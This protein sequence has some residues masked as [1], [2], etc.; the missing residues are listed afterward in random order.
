MTTAR[1]YYQNDHYRGF[2]VDGHADYDAD[3]DIV[4]AAVSIST[5]SAVN[6]LE[7]LLGIV[8]DC[9]EDEARGYLKCQLPDGLTADLL[10]QSDLIIGH[11]AIAL[12]SLAQ[13][14]PKHV[15]VSTEGGVKR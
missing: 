6:A 2:E 8:P 4:C 11:L 7:Q 10:E 9:S 14:Y 15:K 1:L 12:R 13:H 5:I 3:R